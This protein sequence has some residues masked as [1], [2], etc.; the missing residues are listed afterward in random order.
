[1]WGPTAFAS[2]WGPDLLNY[3]TPL[4]LLDDAP[5]DVPR[6][7]NADR[8]F[9]QL[10]FLTHDPADEWDVGYGR[11]GEQLEASGLAT[12]LWT[13]PFQQTVFGTDLYTDQLR[14]PQ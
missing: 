10:H 13:A 5:P 8:R 4:P 2:S 7:A 6:I 12:H 1:V 14:E 3:A 11:F 9:L